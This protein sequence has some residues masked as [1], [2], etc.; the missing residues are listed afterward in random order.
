M[1]KLHPECPLYKHDTCKEFINPKLCA[2]VREDKICLKKKQKKGTKENKK[3]ESEIETAAVPD[4][5]K[6]NS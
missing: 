4:V 6:G 5:L 3:K 2:V 1:S